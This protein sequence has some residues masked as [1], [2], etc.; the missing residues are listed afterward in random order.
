MADIHEDHSQ[1][2]KEGNPEKGRL[3]KKKQ[4]EWVRIP[5]EPPLP[6]HTLPVVGIQYSLGF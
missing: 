5:C 1:A 2:L 3:A 6:Y 4:D